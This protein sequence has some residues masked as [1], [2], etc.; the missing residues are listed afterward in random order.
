MLHVCVCEKKVS[1]HVP[2]Q[3]ERLMEVIVDVD[4]NVV[5]GGGVDIGSGKLSVNENALLGD[6]Q[7]GDGPIGD[8]PC[9]EEVRI[10]TPDP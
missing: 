6:S 10:F 8:V 3:Q 7:R 4:D 9:E 2:C 5:V 1:S